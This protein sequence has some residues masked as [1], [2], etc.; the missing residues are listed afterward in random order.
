MRKYL[1]SLLFMTASGAPLSG[2]CEALSE[3]K[4]P[5]FDQAQTVSPQAWPAVQAIYLEPISLSFNPQWLKDRRTISSAEREKLQA[6]YSALMDKNLRQQLSAKGWAL[7][8]KP[9]PDTLSLH[10]EVTEL[11]LNAPDLEP[12]ISKS[13][14]RVAG[15]ARVAFTLKQADGTPLAHLSD[16]S[17]TNEKPG[18]KL[19]LT[20]RGLNHWDFAHLMQRWSTRLGEFLP[21]P[22]K[23]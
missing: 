2:W 17:E 11:F 7:R 18:G 23:T 12:T 19:G 4:V 13:Y 22:A 21:P 14:V 3:A 20:N 10:T 6:Q 8:D 5:G 15:S 1:L 9:G 16:Y